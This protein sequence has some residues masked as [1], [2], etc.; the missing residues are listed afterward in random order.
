MTDLARHLYESGK[1]KKIKQDLEHLVCDLSDLTKGDK[2]SCSSNEEDQ[3]V[4][5][6]TFHVSINWRLSKSRP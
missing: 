2:N 5:G 4:D 1:L 3:I 6:K